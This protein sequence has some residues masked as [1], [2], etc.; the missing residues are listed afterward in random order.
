MPKPRL[1][2]LR[3]KASSESSPRR[4]V[5]SSRSRAE[6]GR[7]AGGVRRRDRLDMLEIERRG[8]IGLRLGFSL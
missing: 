7:D 4:L 3:A 6:F 5:L 1:A 2:A 8:L